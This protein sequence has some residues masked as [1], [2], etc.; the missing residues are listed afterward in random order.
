MQVW[1]REV[2]LVS[3]IHKS[4]D[5]RHT[6]EGTQEQGAREQGWHG[7]L[8]PPPSGACPS[9][10]FVTVFVTHCTTVR[11]TALARRPA[12]LR[13]SCSPCIGDQSIFRARQVLLESLLE[14]WAEEQAPGNQAGSPPARA[15]VLQQQRSWARSRPV[16]GGSSWCRWDKG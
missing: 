14:G 8:P 6:E 10:V 16:H 5:A 12:G 3:S 13:P 9:R 7:Q 11:G 2:F 1:S 15:L 4:V